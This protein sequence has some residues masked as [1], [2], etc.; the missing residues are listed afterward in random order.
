MHHSSGSL[1]T[2]VKKIAEG[3]SFR[4]A[5]LEVKVAKGQ[6]F[7]KFLQPIPDVKSRGRFCRHDDRRNLPLECG[8]ESGC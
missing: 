4:S 1:R 5:E 3:P 6:L 7:A 8:L 2:S